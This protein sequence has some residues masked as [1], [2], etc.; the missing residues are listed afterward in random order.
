MIFSAKPTQPACYSLT[1]Y[2]LTNGGMMIVS[3]K[4]FAKPLDISDLNT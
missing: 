4:P 3:C 1:L 2:R